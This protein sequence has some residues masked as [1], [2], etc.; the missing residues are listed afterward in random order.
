M[1]KGYIMNPIIIRR[2]DPSDTTKIV[3]LFHDA[4]HARA[5]QSGAQSKSQ[6][7]LARYMQM[8]EHL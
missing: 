8:V 4:V 6:K 3:A 1:V 7:S 5:Y 2:F